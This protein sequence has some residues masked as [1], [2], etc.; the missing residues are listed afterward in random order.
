MEAELASESLVFKSLNLVDE[1][2]CLTICIRYVLAYF[3]LKEYLQ[4]QFS[5]KKL[6]EITAVA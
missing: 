1:R 6:A 2:Q 5:L 4:H 3:I